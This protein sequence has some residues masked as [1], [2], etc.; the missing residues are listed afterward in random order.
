M[1]RNW[2]CEI[3]NSSRRTEHRADEINIPMLL[4]FFYIFTFQNFPSSLFIP[5]CNLRLS[6]L[7]IMNNNARCGDGCGGK[8]S[9]LSNCPTGRLLIKARGGFL[10]K[11]FTVGEQNGSLSDLWTHNEASCSCSGEFFLTNFLWWKLKGLNTLCV[12]MLQENNQQWRDD[13]KRSFFFL[14]SPWSSLF[15]YNGGGVFPPPSPPALTP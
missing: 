1:T 10:L 3:W 8:T 7:P 9:F 11:C 6:F 14:L 5:R 2:I 4:F 12:T 13:V 15:S